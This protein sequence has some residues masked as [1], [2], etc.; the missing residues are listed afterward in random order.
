MSRFIR[1]ADEDEEPTWDE[2]LALKYYSSLFKE[3]AVCDLKHYK[4]G[5]VSNVIMCY[6]FGVTNKL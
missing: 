1:K 5:N 6:C 2:S 3:F 4:T